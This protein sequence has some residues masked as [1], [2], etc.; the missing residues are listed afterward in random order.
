MAR[1]TK[2]KTPVKPA[3][4]PAGKKNQKAA[5]AAAVKPGR[6]PIATVHD[7]DQYK[8]FG[9]GKNQPATRE[10]E[11]RHDLD[12]T[13][14]SKAGATLADAAAF[15]DGLHGLRRIVR[16]CRMGFWKIAGFVPTDKATFNAAT[17]AKRTD[18]AHGDIK[19]LKTLKQSTKIVVLKP[20]KRKTHRR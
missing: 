10:N 4:K 15:G 20:A 19:R 9:H 3:S 14:Q 18:L 1:S 5:V 7:T 12:E 8:R 2:K 16:L 6:A 11:R 17:E 13:V